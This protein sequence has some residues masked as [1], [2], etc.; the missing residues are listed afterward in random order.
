VVTAGGDVVSVVRR[1]KR[2][3]PQVLFFYKRKGCEEEGG[4]FF[5]LSSAA[6]AAAASSVSYI[7]TYILVQGE[8]NTIRNDARGDGN[9]ADFQCLI[10]LLLLSGVFFSFPFC[11]KINKLD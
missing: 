3:T 10:F 7:I 1:P 9:G 4:E 2:K 8:R 11:S 5:L 6:A